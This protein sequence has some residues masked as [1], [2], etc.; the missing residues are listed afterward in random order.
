M[1]QG[2]A[3]SFA[4]AGNTPVVEGPGMMAAAMRQIAATSDKEGCPCL[5]QFLSL[6]KPNTTVFT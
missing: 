5:P 2:A 1:A 3:Y 6:G 4:M